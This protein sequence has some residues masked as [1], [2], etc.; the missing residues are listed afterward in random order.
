MPNEQ[1]TTKYNLTKGDYTSMRDFFSNISC[2]P[3]DKIDNTMDVNSTWKVIHEEL[4]YAIKTFIPTKKL[5]KNNQQ[6]SKTINDDDLLHKLKNKKESFKF[7]KKYP[8]G[9]NL[10]SYCKARNAV[11]R[12]LRKASM[13]KEIQIAKTIKSNPKAFYQYISSKTTSKITI[14]DLLNCDGSLTTTD[15]EKCNTLN[16]FFSSVFVREN[17]TNIPDFH[18]VSNSK[19]ETV[20]ISEYDVAL[21]LKSLNSSKSPGP[22]L[23]HPKILS[24][25]AGVLA[26]PLFLL[27]NKTLEHGKIPQDWKLAEVRPIF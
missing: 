10:R 26:L 1:T 7:Y 19:L 20:T 8:S 24:E 11:T 13:N 17:I 25:L 27:F 14:P 15:I 22:D 21:K 18:P 6:R 16:N 2:R 5:C 3:N 23:I 4:L 12:G 9:T